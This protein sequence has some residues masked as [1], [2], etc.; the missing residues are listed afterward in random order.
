MKL[1]KIRWKMNTLRKSTQ[2][3][4]GNKTMN[5]MEKTQMQQQFANAFVAALAESFCLFPASEG[6]R[7][8]GRRV[9]SR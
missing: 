4:L 8:P 2:T 3:A 7:P 1:K 5:L 6:K 9:G